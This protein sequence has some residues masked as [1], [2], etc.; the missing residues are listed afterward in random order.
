MTSAATTESSETPRRRARW[1]VAFLGTAAVLSF[2]SFFL[3]SGGGILTVVAT[4]QLVAAAVLGAL[5][6]I[7][8]WRAALGSTRLARV[9]AAL[10]TAAVGCAVGNALLSGR[11][12]LLLVG[13]G[14]LVAAG[15]C[16]AVVES[17]TPRAPVV[18]TVSEHRPVALHIA[19]ATIGLSALIALGAIDLL[20]WGPLE[21][22]EGLQL[23]E[24]YAGLSEWDRAY[25]LFHIVLW[26]VFWSAAV[27][28]LAIVAVIAG[29]RRA[30]VLRTVYAVTLGV[31]ATIVF[32]QF[33]AGFS[34]GMSI[35]DTLP[36]Y[37]GSISGFGYLYALCGQLALVGVIVLT[38]A[39]VR[40]VGPAGIEPTTS[41][42]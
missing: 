17:S 4:A 11:G 32:F 14:L 8:L 15:V 3:G 9:T 26:I 6:L 40:A 38:I 1:G 7:Q 29:R 13:V 16:G 35:A 39:P 19:I 10:V 34:L 25:A 30:V 22:T 41:T 36:P 21:Q 12:P 2:G 31:A 37:A 33:W 27:V 5:G 18:A 24:I 42:V 23:D 28:I 20:V